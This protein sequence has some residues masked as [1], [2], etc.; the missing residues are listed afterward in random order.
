[1]N[2]VFSIKPGALLV[3]RQ[4]IRSRSSADAP[5]LL[6]G[7]F[8]NPSYLEKEKNPSEFF[9][10]LRVF[11]FLEVL[12]AFFELRNPRGPKTSRKR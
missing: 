8:T 5:F 12:M 4:V 11:S 9:E 3:V 1:L 10:D 2:P 7:V 6:C